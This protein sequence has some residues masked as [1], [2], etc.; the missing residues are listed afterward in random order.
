VVVQPRLPR[1]VRQYLLSF[2]DVD[3]DV[4][5]RW[6]WRRRWEPDSWWWP[7]TLW[8]WS[9]ASLHRMHTWRRIRSSQWVQYQCTP[10]V[11]WHVRFYFH[12]KTRSTVYT[13][14]LSQK[15]FTVKLALCIRPPILMIWASEWRVLAID[16]MYTGL[17]DCVSRKWNA[18][19]H[20]SK[21][22]FFAKLSVALKT[23]C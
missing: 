4:C 14:A 6:R 5:C 19:A 1:D 20:D 23:A 10:V 16:C 17:S 21:V 7:L 8:C 18:F 12:I 11:Q 3:V 9:P 2:G 15:R 22:F 13:Y